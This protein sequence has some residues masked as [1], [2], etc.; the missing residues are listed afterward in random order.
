M[1]GFLAVYKR[2]LFSTFVTPVAWVL[3]FVF[4]MVQGLHFFVLISQWVHDP[5]LANDQSPVSAFFG[6]TMVLYLILFLF[7]PAMTMR[8]FAEERRSGM[9]E[10]LLTAPLSIPALVL[11]KYAAVLSTYVVLWLPTTLY[12]A[13]LHRIAELDLHV[14]LSSYLGVFLVGA[15]Y[16]SLGALTSVLTRSQ[17]VALSLSALVI[18][19]LFLIG[20]GTFI[21]RDGTTMHAV[22]SYVSVWSAMSEFAAGIID[23]RRIVFYGTMVSLPLFLTVRI[24]D[25]WRWG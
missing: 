9:I 18:L 7:V 24:I 17:L 19:T 20:L 23:L 15:G 13:T 16:L 10:P 21:T 1:R 6:E 5:S 11:G 14:V 12:V 3:L 8:L 2:E 4:A 22:S 25:S